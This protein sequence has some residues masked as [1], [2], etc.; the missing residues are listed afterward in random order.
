MTSSNGLQA[1]LEPA[2]VQSNKH[3][4]NAD[5]NINLTKILCSKKS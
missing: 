2:Y 1:G 5:F 3:Q 4:H